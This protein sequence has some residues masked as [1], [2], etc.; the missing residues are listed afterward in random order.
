[1]PPP[2]STPLWLRACRESLWG[3]RGIAKANPLWLPLAMFVSALPPRELGSAWGVCL[4]TFASVACW[5]L[6]GTLA[7]DLADRAEDLA[8]GKDRWILTLPPAVGGRMV[9]GLMGLG[10]APIVLWGAGTLALAG[11]TGA[12]ALGVA[13]SAP[14]LRLKERGLL[15]PFACAASVAIACAVLPWAWL[16]GPAS[17]LG[18]AAPAVFLDKWVH[19]HFHQVVDYEADLRQGG[20]T[21]AVRVGIAR[22][23]ATLAWA[24]IAASLAMALVLVWLAREQLPVWGAAV[25]GVALVASGI[26]TCVTRRSAARA[27]LL[28]REL[29]WFYLALTFTLFK[30]VPIVSL[31]AAALRE[32][33]LWG[34]AAMAGVMLAGEARSHLG[35]QYR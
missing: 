29:P 17:V 28:T 23:R 14:P 31:V 20:A 25:A 34:P 4:L 3:R 32:A 13:Y 10:I 1:M 24:A 19:L 22:A 7:N 33:T 30:V 5:S 15:G 12:V 18:L 8:A 16:G 21:F 11:Y 26:Y 9:A 6:S 2:A 27:T 35:Y